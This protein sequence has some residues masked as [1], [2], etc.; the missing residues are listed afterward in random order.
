MQYINQHIKASK[1]HFNK[2]RNT[3]FA[4]FCSIG[5]EVIIGRVSMLLE[6]LKTVKSS[7]PTGLNRLISDDFLANEDLEE[8]FEQADELHAES[9]CS[10]LVLS[11][12]QRSFPAS[13]NFGL[14]YYKHS[15]QALTGPFLIPVVY[16]DPR[17]FF[18]NQHSNLKK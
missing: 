12:L 14:T 16:M 5:R 1:L 2:W 8:Q 17:S 6:N 15:F 11:N 3:S 4:I 7:I 18:Q 13:E 10:V 9:F